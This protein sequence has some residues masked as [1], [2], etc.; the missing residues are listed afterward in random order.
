MEEPEPE[1]H[2]AMLIW[3]RMQF[4][5]SPDWGRSKL[6]GIQWWVVLRVRLQIWFRGWLPVWLSICRVSLFV[7][8]VCATVRGMWSYVEWNPNWV[9]QRE[10][11]PWSK[12]GR[13]RERETFDDSQKLIERIKKKNTL[14]V[15]SFFYHEQKL[16]FVNY[17]SGST[18][19]W[20]VN[21][22][23]IISV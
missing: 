4:D 15:C 21:R 10:M 7:F 9:W 11:I 5:S 18:I 14:Y 16:A 3:I 12:S 17:G 13:E 23:K 22:K 19:S 20:K 8:I 2:K 1:L 6:N